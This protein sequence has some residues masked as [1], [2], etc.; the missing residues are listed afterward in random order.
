[1]AKLQVVVI[2]CGVVG[3][4]I[5]YELSHR[6]D[7]Q[8]TVLE[9]ATPAQGATGAA[10]GIAMGVIS[11]KVKGRNWRLREA[12]LRRY[13]TLLPELAAATGEPVPHNAQGI[14]SLCFDEAELPRWQSL[15]ALR[16]RQGWRLEIWSP[17]QVSAACSHLAVEGVAAGIYSPQDLQI[18][19]TALT[20]ALVAAAQQRGVRLHCG[21]A[22]TGVETAGDRAIAVHTEAAAY[23]ADWVVVTAGLG[24]A[25]LAQQL[26]HPLPLVP[27]LGQGLRVQLPA[28]LGNPDFQPVI[29]GGDIHL[30]PLGDRVYGVAATV[31]FPPGDTAVPV[32]Q[33]EAL[34]AVWEGAIAYCP[35]LATATILATWHG[36]RPRPQ[37]QAAPIIQP[38]EHLPNVILATG[39]YRNGVFLA[40]ATAAAVNQ[41]LQRS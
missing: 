32:P 39:H 22:V 9:Q 17:A 21:G 19:P 25:G 30:V 29:N 5:A 37:G 11:H 4:A 3:A 40:P 16:Q 24:S 36:L 6:P 7:L 27:V 34:A 26:G 14:L 10:L 41:L 38:L 33:A 13:G 20:Q 35:A 18:A 12:S 1:M 15:Q 23:P 31:E 8:I 2:G 28:P